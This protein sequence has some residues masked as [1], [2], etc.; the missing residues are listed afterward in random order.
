MVNYRWNK[1]AWM[2]NVIF[3]EWL[4]LVNKK[5]KALN[6][7][8]LLFVDN[9]SG[10]SF[11]QSDNDC[12]KIQFFPPYLTSIVQP[13]DQGEVLYFHSTEFFLHKSNITILL[14]FCGKKV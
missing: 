14:S 1:N 8:I 7:K 4:S 10:H 13:L 11:D 9:F 5:Y 12:I 6:R 2:K 3:N